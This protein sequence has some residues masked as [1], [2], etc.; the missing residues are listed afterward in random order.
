MSKQLTT[1]PYTETE[2]GKQSL[3]RKSAMLNPPQERR[4]SS[5]RVKRLNTWR[6]R[7]LQNCLLDARIDIT[8]LSSDTGET[9]GEILVPTKS[10][11]KSTVSPEAAQK[12]TCK[13]LKS[14]THWAISV[15]PDTVGCAVLCSF[16]STGV[17]DSALPH[18]PAG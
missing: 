16:I 12:L 11:Q 2:H 5:K 7:L 15:P 6:P 4:E 10:G 18:N 13:G 3:S 9:R 1:Q 14:R 8:R 17:S